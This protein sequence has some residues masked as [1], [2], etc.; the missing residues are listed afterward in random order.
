MDDPMDFFLWDE[1][2]NPDTQF[3]CP[4]CGFHFGPGCVAWSEEEGT[5]V[6]EC[7]ACGCSGIVE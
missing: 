6:Y 1:F 2:F 3:E 4:S 7:P 5:H